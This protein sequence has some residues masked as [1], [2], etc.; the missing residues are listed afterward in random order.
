VVVGT[1][2]EIREQLQA[3]EGAGVQ[4]AMLQWLELDDMDGIE[5]MG[6]SIL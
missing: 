3:L 5:V 6:K 1:A 2:D 4:R